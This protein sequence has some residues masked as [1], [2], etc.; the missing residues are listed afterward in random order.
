MGC[1][2]HK[3]HAFFKNHPLNWSMAGTYA[4]TPG[5]KL[6]SS[7]IPHPPS[8]LKTMVPNPPPGLGAIYQACR[9]VYPDQQ[10]P[11][12]VTAVFKYW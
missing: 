2:I 10:N 12:Q 11:L 5:E 8:S 3:V 7:R 9:N 6:N 1:F 4:P